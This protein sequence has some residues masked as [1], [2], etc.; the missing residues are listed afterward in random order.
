[1]FPHKLLALLAGMALSGVLGCGAG[2]SNDPN[3]PLI[4]GA[5]AEGGAPYITAGPDGNNIGFEVEVAAALAKEL[6]RPIEFK[7]V[8]FDS[9]VPHLERGD[10]DLAMNGLEVTPDRQKRVR[11]SRPYYVYRQQLAARTGDDRFK[12][13]DGLKAMKAITVGT[14]D[15]TAA[16]RLLQRDGVP[17]KTYPDSVGPYKDLELKRI[18]AVMQDL[19]IALYLVKKQDEFKDKIQFVGPPIEPGLYAIA[20]RPRDE[21]L[22]KQIDA[23]LER[24]ARNGTL[25]KI[26]EKWELWNDDQQ[27]I[28][29]PTDSAIKKLL[30]K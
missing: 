26:L 23:A 13:Y 25:Q 7:Q 21:E 16:M 20:L 15:E 19:P 6:G 5:D 24:L 8:A 29:Q 18:D 3:R 30:G 9:L 1:L 17:T 14:L 12:S 22:A 11:F 27:Q 28:D 4:W 10:I 2:Q